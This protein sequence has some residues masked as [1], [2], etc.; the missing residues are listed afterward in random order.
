M[1]AEP[2]SGTATAAA[3]LARKMVSLPPADAPPVPHAAALTPTR[4]LVLKNAPAAVAAACCGEIVHVSAP[5][6]VTGMVDVTWK[7]RT[8]TMFE[9]DVAEHG[10]QVG[11]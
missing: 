8:L 5:N 7:D 2:G 1:N 3:E 11:A 10:T 9:V 6:E 4:L